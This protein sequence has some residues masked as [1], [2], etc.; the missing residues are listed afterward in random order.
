MI[1]GEGKYTPDEV[2]PY[3]VPETSSKLQTKLF[4]GDEIKMNSL[5][6]NVFKEKGCICV[7]CGV[8]GV[9]FVKE[10][11]INKPPTERYHFNLYAIK[12]GEEVLMIKERIVLKSLG[13]KEVM[14]NL[15]PMCKKCHDEDVSLR[16]T[17]K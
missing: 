17:K 14:E 6:L 2:L 15:V 16:G 1:R 12:E 11:E 5:R 8:E 4:D 9:Y 13:G 10:K 3:V 7:K